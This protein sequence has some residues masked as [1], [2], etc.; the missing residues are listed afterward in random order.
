MDVSLTAASAADRR[1]AADILAGIV[2]RFA[3]LS[4]STYNQAVQL[5]ELPDMIRGYEDVK[6]K[7][8]ERYREEVRK[9]KKQGVRV[10]V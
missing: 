5:A 6:M 4:P 1:Q 8:V 3:P 9:M 2:E 7:N 10:R